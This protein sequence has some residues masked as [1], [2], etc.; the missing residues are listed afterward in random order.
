MAWGLE[1]ITQISQPVRSIFLSQKNQLAILSDSQ[2]S[3]SEQA[4]DSHIYGQGI[5]GLS[6]PV[7]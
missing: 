2:I 3:P 1:I 6:T 7:V 4:G 5:R